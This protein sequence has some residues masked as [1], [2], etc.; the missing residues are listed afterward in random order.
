MTE[1]IIKDETVGGDILNE[2]KIKID[3]ERIMVRDIIASR[4]TAEVKT[5]NK[6]LPEYFNGLIK[7]SDAEQT[8]NGFKMKKR[9]VVDPEKQIYVAY[10]AF[11]K[12]GFF[13]LID[14][15]QCESLDQ[16]VL[17]N[18]NTSVSFLKLTPLVGG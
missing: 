2:I 18:E 15:V 14:D 7:P 11:Q 4:V 6:K 17:V 1:L 9:K 5:Y 16:E 13:V 3:S 12:N 10:E 8:L